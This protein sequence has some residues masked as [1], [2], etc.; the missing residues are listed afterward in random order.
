MFH[1]VGDYDGTL[2]LLM[3]LRRQMDRALEDFDRTDQWT[4]S[5]SYP[6]S[7]VYDTGE[8]FVITAEVPG[9]REGDLHVT[10]TQN[11]VMVKGERKSDVPEGY[12]VHRAERCP[13]QFS[14]SYALPARIDP[15][16]VAARLQDG[17]LT[18]TLAKAPEVR[19]RQI[20]VRAS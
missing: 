18:L 15:E 14:R 5:R 1:Y 7:N 13:V 3:Q 11:V 10:A 9:L 2:G 16:G 6:A 12:S 20:S 4:R 19:P 17:V 8:A